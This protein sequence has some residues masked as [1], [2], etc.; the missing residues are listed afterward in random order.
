METD[1]LKEIEKLNEEVRQL[2]DRIDI[3]H[4]P[5]RLAH[6]RDELANA[7]SHGIGAVFFIVSVPILVSYALQHSSIQYAC[8]AAIFGF[9][10]IIT[11]L[12]STLYHSIHHTETKRIMRIFDHVSIFLLIGGSY[13]PVVYHYMPHDFAI[14]FLIVLWIIV[15]VGCVFKALYTG[16]FRLA[17]TMVY[18]VLGFMV[19]FIIKPLTASMSTATFI[20]LLAGGISYAAGVPFYIFKRLRYNH[21]IWHAFVF[22]G[23]ILHFCVVANSAN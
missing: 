9:T 15:G 16:R 22:S 23:S 3:E 4:M 21:A 19:L 11:Y 17:S 8:C 20:M 7:V 14:P 1:A 18:V 6:L 13:T 5:G 2:R 12:S 10:L